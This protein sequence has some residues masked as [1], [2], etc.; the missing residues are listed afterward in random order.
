MKKFYRSLT[1]RKIAG[2]LGG[3]GEVLDI[4][5]NVLRLLTILLFF[6]TGIIPVVITYG[7]AWII[8]PDGKPESRDS[9][10]GETSVS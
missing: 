2:V 5:P 1:D 10:T 3:M 6:I 4:D 9:Q 7:V 8:L